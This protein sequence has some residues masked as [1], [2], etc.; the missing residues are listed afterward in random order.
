LI[1]DFAG[2]GQPRAAFKHKDLATVVWPDIRTQ[3][4][5]QLREALLT[6]SVLLQNPGKAD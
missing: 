1:D 5:L 2:A 3:L 4:D 6:S